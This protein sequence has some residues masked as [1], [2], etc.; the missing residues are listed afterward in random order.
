MTTAREVRLLVVGEQKNYFELIKE[1]AEL[2]SHHF[3]ITCKHATTAKNAIESLSSFAPSV[4]MLDVHLSGMNAFDILEKCKQQSASVIITSE[5]HSP[6]IERSAR[7]RGATA[8]VTNSENPEE[9]EEL[10]TRISQLAV[11]I[12]IEH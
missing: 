4:V 9:I 11:D 12:K 8:Y 5:K 6:A 3:S 10:L 2:C 7:D 1:Q